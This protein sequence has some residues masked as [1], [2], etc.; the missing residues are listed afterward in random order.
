MWAT[1]KV[2]HPPLPGGLTRMRTLVGPGGQLVV[3]CPVSPYMS[4]AASL[5]YLHPETETFS[6]VQADVWDD[7]T[8]GGNT[9]PTSGTRSYTR[10]TRTTTT[11]STGSS[12]YSHSYSYGGAPTSHSTW[13]TTSRT[14]DERLPL[15]RF[16]LV[17]C[18][19]FR[20]RGCFSLTRMIEQCRVRM[21]GPRDV[22]LP[23]LQ[24]QMLRL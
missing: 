23:K 13:D 7:I 1:T 24:L 10:T 3:I 21:H 14:H 16:W 19:P 5:P 11:Y 8:G 20:S 4:Q 9:F 18:V 17:L 12:G 22:F 2:A 6:S 15:L